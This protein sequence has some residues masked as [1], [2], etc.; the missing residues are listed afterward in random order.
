M[1][2]RIHKYSRS[3]TETF[4]E[5]L[6]W[7][8]D[9][10]SAF[11]SLCAHQ[12]FEAQV[13]RTPQSTA[14][15]FQETT[16]SYEE[17]NA[18]A[19]QLARSLRRAGVGPETFVGIAL[20]RSIDLIVAI[21]A[22]WKAGGAYVPLDPAYPLDRLAF[23][24]NDAG[25]SLLLTHQ[26]NK[27]RLPQ[28]QIPVILLDHDWP[29]IEREE[30]GNL[31]AEIQVEHAA[32]VI[33][34][35]G[36]TGTPKGVVVTHRGIGNMALSMARAFGI[37]VGSRVLQ[38]A[39]SNFDA[40]VA[41]IVMTLFV[42]ATLYEEPQECILPGPDL[43]QVLRERAI[44]AVIL[45]PSA[46][47]VMTVEDLP[48]L[49]TIIAAG[50][51][52][53]A[54]LV[55]R[56]GVG[57][58]FFNAY[59]PTEA[60]VC[61]TLTECTPGE[62]K[63]SIGYPLPHVQVYVLDANGQQ[64]PSGVEGELYIGGIGLAR[65]Y[66]RRPA[67]TAERFIFHSWN[68]EPA[69]RL[70]KTGDLVRVLPS[71]ALDFLRR[72]DTQVK[73]RGFR[74]ELAEIEAVLL[75]HPALQEAAVL[76]RE[77]TPGERYLV[78]YI[79][80]KAS[81][82][83]RPHELRQHLQQ[84]LP[85]YMLPTRYVRLEQLPVTPNGKLDRSAFPPPTADDWD[86]QE[87]YVAPRTP[88]EEA[89]AQIWSELFR[90][91]RVSIQS[92][93]FELGGHSLLAT[94]IAAH[95]RET[96]QVDLPLHVLFQ[97]PT[98][99]ALA[100]YVATAINQQEG[101]DPLALQ[102]LPRTEPLPLSFPQESIW[103]L[104][105][106]D[107]S[108]LSYHAQ[109]VLYFTGTLHVPVL[110]QSLSEIVR[111]HEIFR[112]TY[113]ALN[114][115]PFA[116][117][118]EPW[119]VTLP[120]VDL[121]TW[122][123]AEREERLAQL[124]RGDG[125]RPFDLTKLP[126]VRWTLVRTAIDTYAL[127]HTEHHLVHDGWSF[128][129]FLAELHALYAAF[130]DQQPSPLPELPLQLADFAAWQRQWLQGERLATQ[131]DYW[132]GQ[133]QNTPALAL[134]TDHPRPAQQGFHGAV[135]RVT[136]PL[137]LSHSLKQFSQEKGVTLFMTMLATFYVLLFRYTGQDDI[138]V[139]SGV[140]NRRWKASEQLIGMLVNTIVLRIK[141]ADLQSFNDLLAAVRDTT[142]A[143]YS[144][145]DL[146]FERVVEALA[147]PRDLSRNPVFQAAFSFHDSPLTDLTLP[148]LALRI[149]EGLNYGSAKFDLNVVVI[150]RSEQYGQQP[151]NNADLRTTIIW[152]YN[153]DL[154]ETSTMQ[155]MAGHYIQLLQAIVKTPEQTIARLPLLTD[156]EREQVL[157]TWNAT[158]TNFP[159]HSTIHALFEQ[160]AAQT[161]QATAL[162]FQGTIVSYAA[163][164][165]RANQL[166]RHLRTLGVGPEVPVGLYLERSAES[167]IAIL[168][169]LK[170]GG[171]Y[172][173]LDTSYPQERLAFIAGD[174]QIS[175]L[176]TDQQRL[177]ALP[178]YH[179]HRVAIDDEALQ[180]YPDGN[181]DLAASADQFAYSI[182][183]SGST[184]QPKG[185]SVIHR[186][187]VRLAKETNYAHFAPD[188]RFLQFAPLSFDAST[189][190]IWGSLLNGASLVIFPPY[191]PSL[192]ELAA[193]IEQERIT[194]L[195]LTA[196]LFHQIVETQLSSLR[197]VRQLLSGGDVLSLPH[198]QKA[199]QTLEQTQIIN[200][201][202][203]TENTTFTTTYRVPSMGITTSSV[204]IG[205][206]IAN[207]EVYILD[208]LLQPVP[209]GVPG[210]LYIGGAGVAR[211]YVH[212]P[213]LTEE[214]FLPNPFNTS[215]DAR[216]YRSGDLVRYLAD[217]NI[218][219][220][221]RKDQQVKIR[222][223]RIELGE[224]ESV[225]AKHAAI[226]QAAVT[227]YAEK[228]VAEDKRLVAYIVTSPNHSLTT[229]ELHAWLKQRL[230]DYMI[231]AAFVFLPELP[232]M[233]NGKVDKAALPHP[234]LTR[235]EEQ[236]FV[237]ARNP[238]E[239]TLTTIWQELLHV[240][241]ISI[242][243]N[244]FQ[245]GGHSLLATQL[246]ARVKTTFQ[247]S[248]PLRRL[249]EAPT[250]A[251]LAA[252]IVRAQEETGNEPLP[253]LPQEP[254]PSPAI[255]V[256]DIAG[257][258]DEEV[259]SLLKTLLGEGGNA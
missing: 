163:V 221:G 182:Y 212:R 206:P 231:P 156:A 192:E 225:L 12:H 143:G 204:P 23:M 257:L 168:A 44:T 32:Y 148:E 112:T 136:L 200:A 51:P 207:T 145:Q 29:T 104:T 128:N 27:E 169:I 57:R 174:A 158:R 98:I 58:R 129:V 102:P 255:S 113:D 93:F 79:V 116:R 226:Q 162:V 224:I 230:P 165:R 232:L 122:P 83:L 234:T 259:L 39:S 45:P 94:R 111:R 30:E 71:G 24:L 11:F 70:Y 137:D 183:T 243:D 233:A 88:V 31:S 140:A 239:E 240:P 6:T 109:A 211:G 173:P 101:D 7:N 198:V 46:L 171:G 219:F 108:N 103:F 47:S 15:S 185:V 242:H 139:G 28:Q 86:A 74:I 56:W 91:N 118:H 78:A 208:A 121:L 237:A 188:E 197:F 37:G 131:L 249:F 134:P 63:P 186:N 142:I 65:E 220:L 72:I 144:H 213:D 194:T 209:I 133:L 21:L 66:L 152:E 69:Q 19:N 35:S 96:F 107:P 87:D 106:L 202:G 146:P 13:Q 95:I 105:Q 125:Q 123:E 161:P 132:K 77:N 178:F 1:S 41:E 241:H 175:V 115:R 253:L 85:D 59:G 149:T 68:N 245:L 176:I 2:D 138:S 40:S 193:F 201:Y 75:Q 126:L 10:S 203:P 236:E 228:Q 33:Y 135:E 49:E 166:A 18:R 177:A 9:S 147:L 3:S 61:A 215:P 119:K 180:N 258:S 227:V 54:E 256:S 117:V 120:V 235:P 181:L 252:A 151:T 223:F 124:C 73:I 67:L 90:L 16:L 191:T 52:C 89:I 179:G 64:V 222:G 150:P 38:F 34:T 48:N 92:N 99:A 26:A 189:F 84:K 190:E 141:L 167:I 247:V 210:E 4:H 170:A 251:G 250:I 76:A 214:R 55:N 195:W 80:P 153:T 5:T 53:P 22:V 196:G 199:Q 127:I 229:D 205:R 100:T 62:T 244:F 172:V 81:A 160:Q 60:T 238:L 254:A 25:I 248:L 82:K 8:E 14:I 110:E 159:R 246:I 155:R 184:G 130:Y 42:G 164:N 43:L 218:E 216:L 154:F 114:G 187:V 97:Q 17:V 217:G 36:S 20:P 50:E 157:V